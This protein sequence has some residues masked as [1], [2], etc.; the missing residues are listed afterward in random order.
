MSRAAKKSLG[1]NFL[2][3]GNLQRKI[4]QGLN[5][6][7]NDE[8]LEVGPGRGALTQHLAGRCRNLIL[9]ELDRELARELSHEYEAAPGVRIVQGDILQ[10]PLQ[11]LSSNVHELKVVGNIPYN[12]TSPLLFHLL[13][14]PRPKEIVLMVQREVGHRILAEAGTRAF[15][16]LTVGV[17]T[18]AEVERLFNVP[19]SAFRPVPAVDSVV[20]RIRPHRPSP[21]SQAQ[22]E[23]LRELTRQ[24]FQ[25]RRKQ[26]QSILRRR[27]H[28][29]LEREE[30][31]A[32]EDATGFDLR[33]RP[34][35]FSP[36][37]FVRLSEALRAL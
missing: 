7:P 21:L 20:L 9:V 28:R 26:F 31:A 30:I 5:P 14:R 18:I 11:T 35:T 10:I 16:A 13:S 23:H 27:P 32:L 15:G 29:P 4:V 36:G 25:H 2:V 1:Q 37:D 17:R 33:R 12:I 34:E 24:A 3:D 22:E 8:I 6:G 19:A